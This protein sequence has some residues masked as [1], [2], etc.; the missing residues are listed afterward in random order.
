MVAQDLGSF[1]QVAS[2]SCLLTQKDASGNDLMQHPT[3][4]LK[5]WDC[6]HWA[7]PRESAYLYFIHLLDLFF[8]FLNKS[9][10]H[11]YTEKS[12]IKEDGD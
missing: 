1:L 4:P 9:G 2:V 10:S 7:L 5:M 8:F 6:L 3:L 12:L 11:L